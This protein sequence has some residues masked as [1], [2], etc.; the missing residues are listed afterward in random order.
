MTYPE[1]KYKAEFTVNNLIFEE[2]EKVKEENHQ[3]MLSSSINTLTQH[4]RTNIFLAPGVQ[5]VRGDMEWGRYRGLHPSGIFVAYDIKIPTGSP[6]PYG[7]PEEMY[8][9]L[10]SFET[11]VE[12][13]QKELTDIVMESCKSV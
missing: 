9:K 7:T 11:P 12:D 5:Y 13:F 3:N 1:P 4:L 10:W 8:V 6:G 2:K